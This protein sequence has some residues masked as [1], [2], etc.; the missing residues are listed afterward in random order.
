MKKIFYIGLACILLFVELFI[1][2]GCGSAKKNQE[3]SIDNG[4]TTSNLNNE[5][6]A[7]YYTVG[8]DVKKRDAYEKNSEQVYDKDGSFYMVVDSCN[9]SPYYGYTIIRGKIY[10]G[11]VKPGDEVQVI[12]YNQEA[13][14][15]RILAI[16]R[17]YEYTEALEDIKQHSEVIQQNYGRLGI[18][19]YVDKYID[20][21]VNITSP[22]EYGEAGEDVTL[23][24]DRNYTGGWNKG[25][26]IATPGTISAKKKFDAYVY[27][28][29]KEEGG[30]SYPIADGS[31]YSIVYMETGKQGNIKLENSS[32]AIN[33]GDNNVKI[34]VELAANSP[35]Q[36]GEKFYICSGGHS[37]AVGY[38]TKVYD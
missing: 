31:E 26:I 27:M 4:N 6:F 16:S 33:P 5:N 30:T 11:I 20:A 3:N 14:A 25:D 18:E 38:I 34:T 17:L 22:A 19:G 37:V 35:I 36:N 1:F 7:K 23:V 13:R 2:S 21:K 10:R 24:L 28:Y 29:T 15:S 12:A 8:E 9:H 32:D